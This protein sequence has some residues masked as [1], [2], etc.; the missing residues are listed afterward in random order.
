MRSN[1]LHE[2]HLDIVHHEDD[3]A[4]F[5]AP[6]VEAD[7]TTSEVV[8]A[9]KILA[10]IMEIPPRSLTDDLRPL[11]KLLPC[12]LIGFPEGSQGS[13]THELHDR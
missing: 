2:D 10:N 11:H 8:G 6:D 4:E 7:P 5:I 13:E 3:E 1:E 9:A 12:P